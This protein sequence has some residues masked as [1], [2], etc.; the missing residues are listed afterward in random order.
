MDSV[1]LAYIVHCT[2]F[3][4]GHDIHDIHNADHLRQQQ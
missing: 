3:N 1:I 2:S 4:D